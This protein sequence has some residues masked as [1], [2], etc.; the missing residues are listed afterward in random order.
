M[1]DANV[2]LES[3]INIGIGVYKNNLHKKSVF[4]ELM[5]TDMPLDSDGLELINLLNSKDE[6]NE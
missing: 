3:N 1:S 4:Y 6:T 5:P 2:S